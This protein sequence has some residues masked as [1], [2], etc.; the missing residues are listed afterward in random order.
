MS[1]GA[2]KK[3]TWLTLSAVIAVTQLACTHHLW[4]VHPSSRI[5][6]D[7]IGESSGVVVSRRFD[8]ILWT[9]NDSGNPPDLFAIDDNGELA[10]RIRIEGVTYYDWEDIALDD[11][12]RLHLLD[13]ASLREA[14][15]R[16]YI[17]SFPEPDPYGS[18]PVTDVT[19]RTFRYPDQPHDSEALLAWRDELY[20]VTKSWDGSLPRIYRIPPGNGEQVAELRG[21][22]PVHTMVTGGDVSLERRG[23][24]LASYRALLLWE[25]DEDPATLLQKRPY[26]SQLNARQIEAVAW[27]D[28]DL[29]LTNEQR[30]IFELNVKRLKA[31]QA[32]FLRTPRKRVPRLAETPS[33]ASELEAWEKGRWLDVDTDHGPLRLGRVA[34]TSAALYFGVELPE[35][36][37]LRPLSP[38]HGPDSFDD[39]FSPG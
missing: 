31:N 29:I 13:N 2:A 17:Y 5:R 27:S 3:L 8:E 32:P 36:L 7:S 33:V 6:S 37:S 12:G 28:E 24:V 10:R 4:N 39:W 30:D 11:S 26:I 19:V 1:A 35:G 38:T 14:Q 22:V 15:Q 9:H 18:G 25:G 20:V 23:I 16:S 34:W 21:E